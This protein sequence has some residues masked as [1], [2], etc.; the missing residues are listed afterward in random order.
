MNYH[1]VQQEGAFDYQHMLKTSMAMIAVGRVLVTDRL[2]AS[3]F[4]FL[5]H[6]PH[7]FV[8]QSYSKITNTREVAFN[9]SKYCQ[10]L[11]DMKYNKA[12]SLEEA[13]QMAEELLKHEG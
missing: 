5:L 2:H 9:S 3:I 13:V 7:V 11:Q 10:N 12:G 8:D 6:K 1:Q 4:G